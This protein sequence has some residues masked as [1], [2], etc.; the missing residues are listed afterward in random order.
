MIEPRQMD[1][2]PSRWTDESLL[3]LEHVGRLG[4]LDERESVAPVVHDAH[5][6]RP[7]LV[8]VALLVHLLHLALERDAR[9][10]PRVLLQ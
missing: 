9:D 1:I 5:R 4:E 2:Y 6:R 8:D 3:T 7:E 10:A